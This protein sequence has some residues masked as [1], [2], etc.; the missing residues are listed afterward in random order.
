MHNRDF[1]DALGA[2][3]RHGLALLAVLTLAAC[4]AAPKPYDYTA[5]KASK[6]KTLLILPPTN[7]SPEINA[8]ISVAVRA[9]KPL[10]ESGYYVLPVSLVWQTFR[11][12]GLTVAEDIQAVPVQKLREIF[13][14]D[15]ALYID[16]Q[17]YGTSYAV[18]SSDTVV[19]ASARLV[20]LHDGTT[21]WESSA[22]ASS[23]ETRG[24]GG[25]GLP[26][27]LLAALMTQIIDNA[28]DQ[29]FVIAGIAG[30]RLLE[31]RQPDGMLYGPRSSK[32]GTD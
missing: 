5:F 15:A 32:Y 12:N 29:G 20:D 14:A 9:I 23:A 2:A 21:L 1:V 4:V 25:G 10:A 27:A 22:T 30:N 28:T 26:G 6:P 11:E 24:S 8:G 13:G 18:V 16:V 3:A 19:S 7:K 17:E 31:A